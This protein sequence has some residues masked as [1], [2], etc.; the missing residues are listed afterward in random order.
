MH[1][2]EEGKI[3]FTIW[4][5]MAVF[6]IVILVIIILLLIFNE[7]IKEYFEIFKSWYDQG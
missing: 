1:K 4:E 7:K 2:D 5:K 3:K 6:I